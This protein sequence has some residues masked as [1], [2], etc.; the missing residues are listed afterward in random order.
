MKKVLSFIAI[1]ALLIAFM[2]PLG[3]AAFAEETTETIATATETT[4]I[5]DEQTALDNFFNRYIIPIVG[6]TAS[7]AL[8]IGLAI[9][10]PFIRKSSAYKSLS[11]GYS[12][13]KRQAEEWKKQAESVDINA[14]IKQVTAAVST[15]VIDKI[16]EIVKQEMDK[17]VD[18]TNQIFTN[19]EIMSAQL[20]NFL[21][22]A[23]I[24][25]G[26]SVD[27][28]SEL[29]AKS[30]TTA[31]LHQLEDYN[32]ALKNIIIEKLGVTNE[33]LNKMLEV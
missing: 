17:R 13:L 21:S 24:V 16:G 2:L 9:A 25:W 4:V 10:I 7:S 11:V 26:K 1:T 3:A 30:P 19:T 8:G 23:N 5:L 22:A 15:A 31:L 32:L 18:Q 33:D 14:I 20:S 6:V 29:L 27:G 12:S 28:V